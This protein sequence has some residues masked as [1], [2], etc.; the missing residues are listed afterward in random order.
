MLLMSKATLFQQWNYISHA[1]KSQHQR[2]GDEVAASLQKVKTLNSFV[3][4]YHREAVP[5]N[6]IS[7]MQMTATHRA[8][9]SEGTQNHQK[10]KPTG[11][12][13]I[14]W[15]VQWTFLPLNFRER[16]KLPWEYCSSTLTVRSPALVHVYVWRLWCDKDNLLISGCQGA[17][18]R[19]PGFKWQQRR[20]QW[21]GLRHISGANTDSVEWTFVLFKIRMTVTHRIV[22]HPQPAT[23]TPTTHTF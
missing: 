11:A 1:F 23:P 20:Q 9:I 15:L 4:Y 19:E 14:I 21:S 8:N 3:K 12:G 10:Q 17:S 5:S 6:G 2:L 13:L 18:G 22:P 16:S 7:R